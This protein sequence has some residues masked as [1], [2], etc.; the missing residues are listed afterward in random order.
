MCRAYSIV[1]VKPPCTA[2]CG[3]Q[4][5]TRVRPCAHRGTPVC[6]HTRRRV[7]VLYHCALHLNMLAY[8]KVMQFTHMLLEHTAQPYGNKFA[9]LDGEVQRHVRQWGCCTYVVYQEEYYEAARTKTYMRL[10]K[11]ALPP[12]VFFPPRTHEEILDELLEEL[13]MGLCAFF[14]DDIVV[15]GL[16]EPAQPA[17]GQFLFGYRLIGEDHF[18]MQMAEILAGGSSHYTFADIFDG[19]GCE[20]GSEGGE[21]A[22]GV[23]DGEGWTV[24]YEGGK[25]KGKAK[26]EYWVSEEGYRVSEEVGEESEWE[27]TDDE[28]GQDLGESEYVLDLG[29]QGG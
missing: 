18:N 4:L 2:D 28:D 26:E 15:P 12:G 10:H 19:V 23:S 3:R 9:A 21:V 1:F 24:D 25:G 22:E 11:N 5:T 29:N 13:N 27:T 16:P 17:E 20:M 14:D 6:V 7:K 8:P